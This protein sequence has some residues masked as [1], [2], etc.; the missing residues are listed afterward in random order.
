MYARYSV[1]KKKIKCSY[2]NPPLMTEK[3]EKGFCSVVDQSFTIVKLYL[4]CI[5]NL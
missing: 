5:A 4:K 3:Q 1:Y 2:I